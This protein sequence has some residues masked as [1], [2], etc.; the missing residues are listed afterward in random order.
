MKTHLIL[1]F[2]C[3]SQ[4]AF[5]QIGLGDLPNSSHQNTNIN[6]IKGITDAEIITAAFAKIWYN[7][8]FKTDSV[9]VT[10]NPYIVTS[11]HFGR[12]RH[13]H[14]YTI[15]VVS[16][17]NT[18]SQIN[19]FNPL[20]Y[21]KNALTVCGDYP[22]PNHPKIDLIIPIS[23]YTN[24]QANSWASSVGAAMV[25]NIID[26]FQQVRGR[27]PFNFET[28]ALLLNTRQSDLSIDTL[29]AKKD[30]YN[31]VVDS[32]NYHQNNTH[33]IP[34]NTICDSVQI[35]LYYN[36]TCRSHFDLG[37]VDTLS[38]G[39]NRILNIEQKTFYNVQNNIDLTVYHTGGDSIF[40]RQNW[41][42]RKANIKKVVLLH[43]DSIKIINDSI[44]I[45]YSM[46]VIGCEYGYGGS[47]VEMGFYN[48]KTKWQ[49]DSIVAVRYF[50]YETDSVDINGD[51][52]K[53]DDI[54]DV[55]S[56]GDTIELFDCE[57][58]IHDIDTLTKSVKYALS[59]TYHESNIVAPVELNYF[60]LSVPD[61]AAQ[62][63]FL[64][65]QTA[66][67]Q[68][69]SH[70]EVQHSINGI[71]FETI[72]I[73][74]GNGTTTEVF[75]YHFVDKNPS[76]GINYYRLKQVDYDGKFEISDIRSIGIEKQNT[77]HL[78]GNQLQSNSTT[79]YN[80]FN[81][82]GQLINSFNHQFDISQLSSGVYFIKS[83]KRTAEGSIENEEKQTFKFI[84]L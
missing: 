64:N 7:D 28:K 21:H 67:E 60:E 20:N 1:L 44:L 47:E 24:S 19:G 79:T 2:L 22:Q 37:L 11:G 17:F 30:I 5:T 13:Q 52:I 29:Q 39:G 31:T 66:S 61:P 74:N 9:V 41:R 68:N 27:L 40:V 38:I 50:Y 34:V 82:Q 12:R 70:F 6:F 43:N 4:L 18:T 8:Y 65:W 78:Q 42:Y 53:L 83:A 81:A 71:Y 49:T 63:I 14:D 55:Y 3:F 33:I 73:V 72:G 25:Y 56:I 16:A 48:D 76:N 32:L 10:A 54:Y 58:Y 35:T 59:W 23:D 57:S 84:K 62:T 26:T 46:P 80:I 77:I 69:N 15:D 36:D 75:D 51:I 45:Y